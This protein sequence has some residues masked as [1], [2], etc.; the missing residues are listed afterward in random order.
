M[1]PQAISRQFIDIACGHL[2]TQVFIKEDKSPF[3]G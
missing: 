2:P 3:P 1:T